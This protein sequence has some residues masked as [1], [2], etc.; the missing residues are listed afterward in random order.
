MPRFNVNEADNYGG[1]GA[2][3]FFSLNDDGEVASVRFMYNGIDDI[4][5][6]AVHE[7]EIDGKRKAV[8]CIRSY[9]EPKS[10]CPFC[11][12]NNFQRVKVYIPLYDVETGDVKIW[13]RGK[14][15]IPK[16]T[17]VAARYANSS[18]PLVAHT[19][20]IERHGKKNDAQTSYEIY[21]T[22]VDKTRLEDLPEMPEVLGTIILDKTADEMNYYLDTGSFPGVGNSNVSR[23]DNSDGMP[24]GRR[25]PSR[26][27]DAF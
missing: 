20:D 15:F 25:T 7:V 13:E 2:G 23:N 18:T 6:Y 9:D 16:L 1:S 3:Q 21:E 14:K 17:G 27:G 8:N 11:N 4:E 24:I 26:R 22:G 12:A 5:A 19:F 10:K